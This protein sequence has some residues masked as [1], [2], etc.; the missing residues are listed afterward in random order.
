MS[1]NGSGNGK[2][3][4]QHKD[5]VV[6]FPTL[7]E[8]DRIKREERKQEE[9]WRKDYRAKQKAARGNTAEPFFK[10]GNIPPFSKYLVLAII[11]V[12]LPL[13]LLMS[14]AQLL[15]AIYTF[16]F[17]PAKF[18]GGYEWSALAPLTPLTHAFIHG[19]WLH[20]FFN[21]TM[22]LVLG[23]FVEKIYGSR[24]C[25]IFFILC[26]L[27]GAALYFLINPY[28]ATPV[29]GASGGISGFFGALIY[30]NMVQSPNSP[31]ARKFMKYGPWPVIIFWGAF[32]A[33]PGL[34]ADGALAWQAHLGGYIAGVALTY[35]MQKGKIRL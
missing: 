31:F 34:F 2:D 22:G 4:E 19:S 28:A 6:K 15:N 21:T 20:L 10:A 14:D 11:A 24:T 29:I 7:A 27:A 32:M 9:Q 23:M 18:T 35:G 17:V 30:I 12:H 16:G 13:H 5:K 33:L 25:A 1:T 3:P 26:T 8:R